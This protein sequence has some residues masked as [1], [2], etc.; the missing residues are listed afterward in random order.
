MK[1][2]PSHSAFF[3][4]QVLSG[5]KRTSLLQKS[6]LASS[7]V[8]PREV[9]PLLCPYVRSPLWTQ[10]GSLIYAIEGE[11]ARDNLQRSMDEANKEVNA[12][13]CGWN[14]DHLVSE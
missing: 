6:K 3:L 13:T 4:L 7:G 9:Y 12:M 1:D 5:V 11:V 14:S 8:D 2:Q 10:A